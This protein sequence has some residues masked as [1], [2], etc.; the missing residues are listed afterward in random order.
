M[1][2]KFDL[3]IE[4]ILESWEVYNAIREIIANAID[5]KLLSKTKEIKIY[6]DPQ[7][8]W[9]IRDYGRGLKYEHLTQNENQEK[10]SNPHTIGKFGVGLKDALATLYRKGVKVLIKSK[11]HDITIEMA[12]KQGFKDIVT[13]HAIIESPSEPEMDGTDFILENIKDEDIEQ[14]KSLFIQYSGLI[15][16]ESTNYGDVYKNGNNKTS[17][18]YI[19]GVK[20][21]S[22]ENFLFSYNITSINKKIKDALNRERTN[23]GRDAYSDRVKSILLNCKSKEISSMLMEDLQKMAQGKNHD[24]IEWTDINVH[25]I[26]IYNAEKPCLFLTPQQTQNNFDMIENAQ[27]KGLQIITINEKVKDKISTIRDISGE[28][29]R[30]LNLLRKQYNESYNFRFIEPKDLTENERKIFNLNETILEIIGGKPKNLKEIKISETMRKDSSTFQESLGL[31]E[32]THERIIIK[33][34][35][36]KNLSSYCGTFLHEIV[37]CKTGKEDI[38]RE[39][40]FALTELLGNIMEKLI[41]EKKTNKV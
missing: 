19:N 3:N 15:L 20:V 37:H 18:I 25:A 22:E 7:N 17:N 12:N 23:V 29:I 39:F 11:F 14:A 9:H 10:L 31:W 30:D 41:V 38:T 16:V 13:L 8:K 35:Q 34:D 32:P 28:P 2:N 24:E 6:K 4:E 21:S 36:L 1:A 26:K 40:E 33:R 27:K 5:E